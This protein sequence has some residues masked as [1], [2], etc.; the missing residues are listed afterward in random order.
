M[1]RRHDGEKLSD[2]LGG[3]RSAFILLPNFQRDFEW[4]LKKQAR[5]AASVLADI[6]SGSVLLMTGE[7]GDFNSRKL[8]DPRSFEPSNPDSPCRYLLDGQQ[9]LTTLGQVFDDRMAGDWRSFLQNIS[10]PRLKY[11]WA[12]R[13]ATNEGESDLFGLEN[14]IFTPPEGDIEDLK[15]R[16]QWF[17]IGTATKDQSRWFHP[18]FHAKEHEPVRRN[19]IARACRDN[20]HVPLWS[21]LDTKQGRQHDSLS[22]MCLDQIA[23]SRKKELVALLNAEKD[24]RAP[25]LPGLSAKERRRAYDRE[26]E[27]NRLAATWTNEAFTWL[28]SV[29]DYEVGTISLAPH[30]LGRAIMV[31]ETINM[32]GTPLDAFDLVSAIYA[33]DTT[34]GPESLKALLVKEIQTWRP[35]RTWGYAG[36]NAHFLLE[37]DDRLSNQFKLHFLQTL[38]GVLQG[39]EVSAGDLKEARFLDLKPE[40]ISAHWRSACH[41]VLLAWMFLQNRCGV[42]SE[43]DLRNKLVLLPVSIQLALVAPAATGTKKKAALNRLEYWY[44]SSVLTATYTA[45]QNKTMIWDNEDLHAWIAKRGVNKFVERASRALADEKYSDDAALIDQQRLRDREREAR[46]TVDEYLYQFVLARSGLDL[47]TGKRMPLSGEK[48]EVHHILPLGSATKVGESSKRIRRSAS[49]GGIA[50]LLNSPLNKVYITGVSNRD[51][52]DRDAEKYFKDL[53]KTALLQA[54]L[55]PNSIKRGPEEAEEAYVVRVLRERHERLLGMVSMHLSSLI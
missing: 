39:G 5:L 26:I 55:S 6:P 43:G 45:N 25:L 34:Q 22:Y 15:T 11:R 10:S 44:W 14:F 29:A 54:G 32:P 48:L 46:T 27:I 3:T 40:E 2:L 53:D 20:G 37:E 1:T 12:L 50:G 35:P 30:E 31:F 47:V 7:Q 33:K 19:R 21:T 16:I 28:K 24:L 4:D 52:R 18:A 51:I 38:V 49:K 42:A 9:R 17:E 13:L 41:G 8:G 23:D 36:W